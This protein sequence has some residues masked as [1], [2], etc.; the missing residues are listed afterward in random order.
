MKILKIISVAAPCA[1]LA[2]LAGSTGKPAELRWPVHLDRA[3]SS[4]FCEYRDGRFHAG[5][6]VRT[7]GRQGVPCVALADGWISRIRAGSRGYGK[8]LHLTI[9]D[10]LQVV[11]GHL[12]EYIPALEDTLY[13][14]QM[15]DTTY[16]VDFRPPAGRFRVQAGDTIAWSGMTG[17]TAPHVHLELRDMQD[18]PIDPFTTGLA[19]P[20]RLHPEVSRV[21][22]VPLSAR[23]R[24]AGRCLPWGVPT[25]RA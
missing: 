2:G 10:S 8:A 24:V 15:I 4:S 21:V 7:F 19:L 25:R 5:I 16:A 9:G 23:A 17:T 11:Y 1:L 13:A 3:I 22:F 20:D 18:R 6:D 12:S 14:A